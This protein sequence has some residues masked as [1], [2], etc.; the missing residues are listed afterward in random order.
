MTISQFMYDESN[1]RPPL[2]VSKNPFTCGL[3]G[4]TY[5]AVEVKERTANLARAL[6]NEFG[7][8][9]NHGKEWDKVIGIFSLNT[10]SV[11]SVPCSELFALQL[12]NRPNSGRP[13]SG[14]PATA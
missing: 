7:I 6:S 3:S 12:P 5:S 14:R 1:G 10:V 8:K 2:A 13:N 4:K 11:D 9:A